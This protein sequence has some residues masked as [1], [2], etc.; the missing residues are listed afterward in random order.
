MSDVDYCTIVTKSHLSYA[1]VLAKTLQEHNPNSKFFVLLADQRDEYFDPE[2]EPFD[3]ITLEELDNQED[4]QR[5]CFYYTPSELC[6][7]LRAWLHEYMFQNSPFEKWIYLDADMIVCHSLNRISDQLDHTSI[8]L[9]PHLINI[10]PPQSIDVKAIRR[11]ESYLLRNGGIYNGGFLALRRTEESEAFIRYFKDRLRMYGFD[12]RPMQSGDQ[13]W[14]TCVPL[15]FRDVSVLRD[16]GGNLA[17]WNLF[18]RNIKQDS[19][20]EIRVNGEPL[21]FFHF[22]GFD[23]NTPHKL[24]TYALSSELKIVPSSIA[25]LAKNY[26]RLLIDNGYE[27]SSNYPYAFAK[28]KS[29]QIITPMMRRLYFEDFYRGKTCE[30]SPF[31]QY[32]Y[33]KTRLRSQKAKT[34]IR[35]AGINSLTYIKRMLKSDYYLDEP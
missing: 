2:N 3:L 35:N 24:T 7:C 15:Y 31:E 21:L 12:N 11:L 20:G 29:G 26:R 33:F 1:R 13:F 22:A 16:P 5:M 23:M 32:D 19:S 9:S 30:G 27:V 17:Y 28:F 4:I 8:M 25:K 34:F 18:E 6:F 10:D 14:L